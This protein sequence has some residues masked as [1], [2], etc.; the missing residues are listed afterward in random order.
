MITPIHG[1]QFYAESDL[2][3]NS[4]YPFSLLTRF[5]DKPKDCTEGPL[6]QLTDQGQ[7]YSTHV[8][9]VKQE[10]QIILNI[11]CEGK[12]QFC[13]D[14]SDLAIFW[15]A[16]GTG[17]E[18]YLQ[19]FGASLFLEQHGVP[20]I[21]ANTL[22]KD[23]KG[24]LLIAPSR[25]GKSSLS[26]SMVSHGFDLINDDMIALHFNNELGF[27]TYPSWAK[28]R[29]WPDSEQ[30]L[31]KNLSIQSQNKVHARFAKT[32]IQVNSNIQTN[33]TV[34]I[35]A[36]FIL[37][38]HLPSND[39]TSTIKITKKPASI[40]LMT[41]LQNSMLADAYRPLNLEQHRFHRLAYFVE[42]VPI[43]ELSFSSGLE[44]LPEVAASVAKKIFK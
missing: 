36:A 10:N 4:D 39:H 37:N 34:P 27:H 31:S 8:N 26:A 16:D 30:H 17:F 32:E 2:L 43:Y 20:C 14:E 15:Q 6:W 7:R 42:Q 11:D 29:L 41:L 22:F 38:R 28:L 18:H 23:G 1:I 12:G 9:I 5:V 24:V 35:N 44:H 40:A 25:M 13:F 33:Q 21:H 19:T 3:K